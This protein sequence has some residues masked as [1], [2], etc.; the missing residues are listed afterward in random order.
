MGPLLS[1]KEGYKYVFLA[2]AARVAT[3]VPFLENHVGAVRLLGWCRGACC[4]L[5]PL[6]VDTVF[7]ALETR[8]GI[9]LDRHNGEQRG[10]Q[11]ND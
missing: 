2:G 10:D 4:S 6:L 8:H 5:R 9:R 3:N 7:D 11:E 1:K